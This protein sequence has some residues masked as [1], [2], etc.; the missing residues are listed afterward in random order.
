MRI[1]IMKH[2]K[3]SPACVWKILISLLHALHQQK[4]SLNFALCAKI[5]REECNHTPSKTIGILLHT[6]NILLC[7]T[8]PVSLPNDRP[9]MALYLDPQ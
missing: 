3:H 8:D 7:T 2:R 6:P 4:P 9:T 5:L 1:M